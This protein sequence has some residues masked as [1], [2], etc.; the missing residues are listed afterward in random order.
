MEVAVFHLTIIYEPGTLSLGVGDHEPYTYTVLSLQVFLSDVK[1]IKHFRLGCMYQA[2]LPLSYTGRGGTQGVHM[3]ADLKL[4]GA[5]YGRGNILR[6][7]KKRGLVL[8]LGTCLH[9]WWIKQPS[10]SGASRTEQGLDGDRTC[11]ASEGGTHRA[12]QPH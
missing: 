12:L 9:T 11:A 4:A 5:V 2:K 3:W 6:S 7:G 8:E 1:K 10:V